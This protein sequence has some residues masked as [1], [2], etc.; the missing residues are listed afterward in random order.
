[1]WRLVK[2]RLPLP[3]NRQSG[4]K[5]GR[6]CYW[7]QS[8]IINNYDQVPD[9]AYRTL[10]PRIIQPSIRAHQTTMVRE[11]QLISVTSQSAVLEIWH[12]VSE[13]LYSALPRNLPS[14]AK[15][16]PGRVN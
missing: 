15:F 11:P 12:S 3:H 14:F 2:F 8:I 9:I 13:I 10:I 6:L 1:M 7:P 4:G 16:V 5:Y